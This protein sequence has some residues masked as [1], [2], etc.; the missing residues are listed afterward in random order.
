MN[1]VRFT[2]YDGEQQVAQSPWAAESTKDDA[3]NA[4]DQFRKQYPDLA[5]RIERTGD[6][7]VPNPLRLLRYR[8]KDGDDLYYSR[9]VTENE[10]ESA[11]EEIRVM[12]PKAQ[13]T[14]EKSK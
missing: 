9:L 1:Q 8:I 11:L 5:Y 14:E 13:I 10:K 2:A 3:L 4:L 6:S 7:K 12:Y